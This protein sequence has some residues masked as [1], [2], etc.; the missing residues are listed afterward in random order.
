MEFNIIISSVEQNSLSFSAVS[1][2]SNLYIRN[3]KLRYTTWNQQHYQ[4]EGYPMRRNFVSDESVKHRG[5]SLF[6][7]RLCADFYLSFLMDLLL[8]QAM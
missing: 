1:S 7:L 4:V 5:P 6:S 3:R 2:Y 8:F